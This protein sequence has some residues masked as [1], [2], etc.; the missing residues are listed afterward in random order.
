VKKRLNFI[1]SL[2]TKLNHLAVDKKLHAGSLL[3]VNFIRRGCS[4]CCKDRI[5]QGEFTF[6]AHEGQDQTNL[7]TRSGFSFQDEVLV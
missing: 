5:K 4:L 1:H 3:G 6:K 2:C 7:R